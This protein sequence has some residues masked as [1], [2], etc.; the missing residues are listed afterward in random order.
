MQ[1]IRE[2]KCNRTGFARL[3]LNRPPRAGLGEAS[4]RPPIVR[5]IVSRW[6]DPAKRLALYGKR[7]VAFKDGDGDL[8]TARQNRGRDASDA[9]TYNR[10]RAVFRNPA[11]PQRS[12]TRSEA[13]C[14][15]NVTAWTARMP[16]WVKAH[17]TQARVPSLAKPLR[18][19]ASSTP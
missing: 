5:P 3:N 17:S 11:M 2:L 10:Q 4:V 6:I 9:C 8:M 7:L 1:Q 15:G 13:T 18:C 19:S 16:G 14:Q 12:I